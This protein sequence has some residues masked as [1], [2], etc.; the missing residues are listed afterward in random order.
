M[1]EDPVIKYIHWRIFKKNR[2]FIIIF[3]GPTG[4]GKTYAALDLAERLSEKFNTP[5]SIKGNVDFR[6]DNFVKKTM[7]PQNKEKGTCFVFEEVGAVGGGASSREW[8]SKSNLFFN[9]FLQTTRHRNQ[10]LIMTTPLFSFL[11]IASR[12]LCHMVCEMVGIDEKQN[13]SYCK[14]LLLQTN[15]RTGKVYNKRL[16]FYHN[17]KKTALKI[18]TRYLPKDNTIKEY[19][20]LKTEY[21]KELN[22][23]IIQD[24]K[25][26]KSYRGKDTEYK[27][28]KLYERGFKGV[29]IA[30][31]LNITKQSVSSHLKSIKGKNLSIINP[32]LG[33]IVPNSL[34]NKSKKVV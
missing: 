27:V 20:K 15:V 18:W 13:K 25:P 12:K 8:Q 3:C 33:T 19:E 11:D 24:K 5:F 26:K 21:T 1:E 28:M 31:F 2:N 32:K 29:E 6:F 22:E 14:A 9:S 34:E 4:S 23:R 10:V 7:L 17:K 16:R 30:S